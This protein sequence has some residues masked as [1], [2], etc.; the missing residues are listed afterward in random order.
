MSSDLA[1]TEVFFDFMQFQIC[2]WYKALDFD[3]V[4]IF[5]GLFVNFQVGATY[6]RTDTDE[7]GQWSQGLI[8]A[9]SILKG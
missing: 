1:I 2:N 7:D 6:H 8:S 9:V 5:I 3:I 4:E